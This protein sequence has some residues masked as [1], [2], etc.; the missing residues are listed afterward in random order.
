[1]EPLFVGSLFCWQN[2]RITW[3]KW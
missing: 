3:Q 1:M 2:N